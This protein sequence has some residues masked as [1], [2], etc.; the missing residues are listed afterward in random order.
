MRVVTI[1]ISE[2]DWARLRF[3][4]YSY[5]QTRSGVMREAIQRGI[6]R[7]YEDASK[8]ALSLFEKRMGE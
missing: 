4:A 5:G 1:R 6:E 8:R 7:D 2:K 3:I